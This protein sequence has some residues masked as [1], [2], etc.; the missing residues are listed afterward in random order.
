MTTVINTSVGFVNGRFYPFE[1]HSATD[2][3]TVFSSYR[4]DK[5]LQR[6]LWFHVEGAAAYV[7][8][9]RHSDSGF[10]IST[11]MVGFWSCKNAEWILNE[12]AYSF[13]VVWIAS[14]C[15]LSTDKSRDQKAHIAFCDREISGLE[16]CKWFQAELKR[17]NNL[18]DRIQAGFE[19]LKINTHLSEAQVFKL[20]KSG[21]V[22]GVA[23]PR[24]FLLNVLLQKAI[25][26]GRYENITSWHLPTEGVFSKRKRSRRSKRAA[27]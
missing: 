24:T 26:E 8:P 18:S 12:A 20:S 9:Y 23:V 16:A 1:K 27:I 13:D 15:R 14:Q 7:S 6:W 10:V 5:T 25:N 21:D 11:S 4:Y 3:E 2:E 19:F 22:I 17:L